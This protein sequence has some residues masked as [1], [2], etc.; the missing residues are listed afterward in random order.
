LP[1]Y[2]TNNSI[3]QI[4]SPVAPKMTPSAMRANSFRVGIRASWALKEVEVVGDCGE[5]GAREVDLSQRERV[6]VWHAHGIPEVGCSIVYGRLRSVGWFLEN[7]D[8]NL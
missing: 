1:S 4:T 7:R 5:V 6:L 2:R 3:H 8:R